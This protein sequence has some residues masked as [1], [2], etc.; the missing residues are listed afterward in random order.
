MKIS[1]KVILQAFQ[2]RETQEEALVAL[3][4]LGFA[5]ASL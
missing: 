5:A 3:Y 4:R 1:K 2:T